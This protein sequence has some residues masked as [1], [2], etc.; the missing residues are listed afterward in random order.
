MP[1]TYAF[2]PR[3]R[4]D[5]PWDDERCSR[6]PWV[7]GGEDSHLS[8]RYLFRHPRFPALQRSS[9]YAFA[10]LGT[11]PYPVPVVKRGLRPEQPWLRWY[12]WAPS[13]F[14]RRFAW[15]VSCYA[16]FNGWLLLSQPPSCLS[17]PTSFAT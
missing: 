1:F 3:L 10:A 13:H 12:A 7:F 6:K 14:R 9:R 11:L 17:K 16:L 5:W 15:L 4:T 8:Y 2:R